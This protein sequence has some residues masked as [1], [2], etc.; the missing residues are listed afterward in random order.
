MNKD[1]AG[2]VDL[3]YSQIQ[4]LYSDEMLFSVLSKE[5][6]HRNFLW[7]VAL[8]K[9]GTTWLSAI[10]KNIYSLRNITT[11]QLVPDYAERP[12]EIDPGLFV[13]P[14]TKDV[15]FRQQHCLYSRYTKNLVETT[16]TKIVFQYRNLEDA[17]ASLV[18]HY[19]DALFGS[20]VEKHAIV[21]GVHSLN[22]DELS[23]YVIDVE[24]PWYCKFLSGWMA[25]DLAT[26]YDFHKI[27]YDAL[28]QSPSD[29]VLQ[30]S[31]S[32]NLGFSEKEVL[33]AINSSSEGFTR[34]NKGVSGRGREVFTGEQKDK[35]V[36]CM[37]YFGL[38]SEVSNL[39]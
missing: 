11:S 24:L 25:S 37:G 20:M 28:K 5:K 18:D 31:N 9:S 21:K 38:G 34:K 35:I 39:L 15:F 36:R 2:T 7:H 32:L 4:A 10:L 8:P 17:L 22:R 13:T 19:D 14:K 29:A 12:Q 16:G 27:N 1:N 3:N 33:A 26:S 23:D 6:N 30:L